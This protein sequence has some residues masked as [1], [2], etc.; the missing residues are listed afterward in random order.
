MHERVP[1][2]LCPESSLPAT[3]IRV[4]VVSEIVVVLGDV[5]GTTPLC[6]GHDQDSVQ[7]I[8]LPDILLATLNL[9]GLSHMAFPSIRKGVIV[10]QREE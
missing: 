9:P 10:I 8:P 3:F 7:Q 2:F 4:P 5:S 6:A 1:M